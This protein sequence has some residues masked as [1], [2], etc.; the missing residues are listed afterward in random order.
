MTECAVQLANACAA[1]KRRRTSCGTTRRWPVDHRAEG[2]GIDVRTAST[3]AVGRW[4]PDGLVAAERRRA[5]SRPCTRA[6]VHRLAATRE[7]A[8]RRSASRR[9]VVGRRR[10]VDERH[11]VRVPRA[12][13]IPSPSACRAEQR[14]QRLANVEANVSHPPE[15]PGVATSAMR[16]GGVQHVGGR[17]AVV[18]ERDGGTPRGSS[19]DTRG[20]CRHASGSAACPSTRW[21]SQRAD[22]PVR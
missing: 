1:R 8:R 19:T 11:D 2:P 6:T 15:T 14:R 18:R 9:A 13:T 22:P 7:V 10:L 21:I 16:C 17:R 3:S 5:T 12:T 4:S 20:N